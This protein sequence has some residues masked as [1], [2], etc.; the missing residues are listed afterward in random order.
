MGQTHHFEAC[1]CEK[2]MSIIWDLVLTSSIRRSSC[3]TT[4]TTGSTCADFH[5]FN[6]V[7]CFNVAR[8]CKQAPRARPQPLVSQTRGVSNATSK[9]TERSD[10]PQ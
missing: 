7:C 6:R 3:L 4:A 10:C 2:Y 1:L 8:E 9:C 5:G